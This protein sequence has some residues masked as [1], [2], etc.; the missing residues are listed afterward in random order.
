MS[1]AQSA[2]E[3]L[4]G[5][6][7]TISVRIRPAVGLLSLL[8]RVVALF[9]GNV[10]P[11][12]LWT[13]DAEGLASVGCHVETPAAIGGAPFEVGVENIV[14]HIVVECAEKVTLEHLCGSRDGM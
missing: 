3:G 12:L 10:G 5:S 14:V 4:T 13:A 8:I 6:S 7:L 1:L 11:L 9:H 2:T